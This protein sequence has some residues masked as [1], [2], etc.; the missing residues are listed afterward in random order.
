MNGQIRRDLY[1]TQQIE[2]DEVRR[3]R[4]HPRAMS[5]RESS[6]E[7]LRTSEGR[8][9]PSHAE[10]TEQGPRLTGEAP[11]M[12]NGSCQWRMAPEDR[13]TALPATNSPDRRRGETP[14]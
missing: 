12:E 10:T 8:P 4:R 14:A 13:C 3:I 1:H 9:A 7:A 11:L 5:G 2:G 6:G